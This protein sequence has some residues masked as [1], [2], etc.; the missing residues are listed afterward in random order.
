MQRL[1][2]TGSA[3]AK[4][5]GRSSTRILAVVR[6]RPDATLK[7]IQAALRKEGIHT[8]KRMSE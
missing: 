8:S 5:S 1:R 3:A 4:P 6:E 7:E 2:G